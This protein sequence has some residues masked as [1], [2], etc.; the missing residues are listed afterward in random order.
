MLDHT[1]GKPQI[2]GGAARRVNR[3]IK[4]MGWAGMVAFRL[5]CATYRSTGCAAATSSTS[6]STTSRPTAAKAT[7]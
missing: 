4:S 2:A 7:P 3:L 6:W 1:Q 5:T